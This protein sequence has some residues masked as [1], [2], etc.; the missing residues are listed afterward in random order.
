MKKRRRMRGRKVRILVVSVALFT[1]ILI[2]CNIIWKEDKAEMETKEAETKTEAKMAFVLAQSDRYPEPLL[3]M[4]ERNPE[5]LDFVLD[6]PEKFGHV[7]RNDIGEVEKGTVP[8][9]LQWDP[10]WGYARYGDSCIAISGCG[11]TALSMVI[12]GLTGDSSVTPYRVA[13]FAEENG[14]FIS[15]T[16]TSWELMTEGAEKFGI[17]GTEI[18][19]SKNKVYDALEKGHPIICSMGPGDFTTAGHFIVLT[20]MENG[21]IRVND[22]NSRARS[23]LLWSYDR[24]EPQI[25]NLWEYSLNE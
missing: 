24:L 9:L 4:L 8:L 25:K 5:M 14:Y 13:K 11:P 15:N 1:G 21:M 22:P 7:Y 20:G 10:G 6:Y 17:C 12:A 23:N 2:C 16:G 18:P 3:E 19:L